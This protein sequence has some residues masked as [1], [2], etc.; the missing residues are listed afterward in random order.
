MTV[1]LGQVLR[2][3]ERFGTYLWRRDGLVV[4]AGD[5]DSVLQVDRGRNEELAEGSLVGI[6]TIVWRWHP[7]ASITDRGRRSTARQRKGIP[8][9]RRGIAVRQLVERED[10]IVSPS[11]S[12]PQP[13]DPTSSVMTYSRP[14]G[15]KIVL[16]EKGEGEEVPLVCH[17]ANRGT[18]R[19]PDEEEERDVA[20]P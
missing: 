13:I 19:R 7:Q 6:T 14:L 11:Q 16:V 5:V 12:V 4:V 10:A 3:V 2:E 20:T 9:A 8:K 1:G 15:I 18:D 17:Q